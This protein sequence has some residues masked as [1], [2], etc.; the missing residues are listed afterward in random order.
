MLIFKELEIASLI[1][2]RSNLKENLQVTMKPYR[3]KEEVLN[4]VW[5]SETVP[6]VKMLFIQKILD[7]VLEV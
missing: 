1:R 3:G 7:K 5:G 4:L 2:F 6:K